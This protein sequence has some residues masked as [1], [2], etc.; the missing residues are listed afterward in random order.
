MMS[1]ACPDSH[2]AAAG[3]KPACLSEAMAFLRLR[4]PGPMANNLLSEFGRF[5]DAM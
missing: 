2:H 1:R 4:F 5:R 3:L